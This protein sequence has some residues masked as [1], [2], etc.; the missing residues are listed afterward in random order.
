M[1]T[2][3]ER[4]QALVYLGALAAGAVVGLAAPTAAAGFEY[5]IT[6]LLIVVLYATFLGIP[7]ASLGRAIRDVRFMAALLLL[8]FV[9][10]PA[11]AFMLSR[12]VSWDQGLVAGVLLVLLTP[13]VDYVIAFTRIA[14]G[15]HERLTAATPLLM[16]VQLVLLP[17]YLL[18]FAGAEVADAI[19]PEPFVSAFVW[20]IVVPLV[21]AALTQAVAARWDPAANLQRLTGRIMVPLMALTLLAV[22]AA[23][24]DVI[25]THATDLSLVAMI[26][27]VFVAVMPLLGLGVGM[28]FREGARRTRALVFSGTTRNSLVVLPLALVL[29]EQWSIVPA[30]VV[31]QTLIELLGMVL[32]V[33]V[34]PAL[35]R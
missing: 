26:F 7:F 17:V 27:A 20:I 2:L 23:H 21:A 33:R 13:C 34:V 31:T 3:L 8:N 28:M 35:V 19:E 4:W 9:I 25:R 1:G 12:F 10:A 6:P 15:A 22:V 24:I 14:G 30:V 18:L 11:V 16:L 5:A 32:L 29:G